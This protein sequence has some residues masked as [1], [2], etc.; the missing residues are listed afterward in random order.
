MEGTYMKGN[1]EILGNNLS[2]FVGAVCVPSSDGIC[3]ADSF[4]P[5]TYLRAGQSPAVTPAQPNSS[6]SYHSLITSDY[7]INGNFPFISPSISQKILNEVEVRTIATAATPPDA[8]PGAAILRA[9]LLTDGVS[10]TRVYWISAA[11]LISV[12]TK[13]YNKV[14]GSVQVTGT[15]FGFGGKTFNGNEVAQQQIIMGLDIRQVDLV[16][17]PVSKTGGSLGS[18]NALA[19]GMAMAQPGA[20]LAPAP[21]QAIATNTAGEPLVDFPRVLGKR[22]SI[23]RR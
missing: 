17:V 15:G 11:S 13:A 3:R 16:S 5:G 20:I 9:R 21:A 2:A 8:F 7:T 10:A 19:Y 23:N 12:S 14:D 18:M 4:A 6:P 1:S 22:A